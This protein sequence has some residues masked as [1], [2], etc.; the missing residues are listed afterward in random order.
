MVYDAKDKDLI[1]SG[2]IKFVYLK[3]FS[4]KTDKELWGKLENIYAGD[5]KVKEEK[6]QIFREKFEQLKMKEEEDIDAYFQCVDETKNT[7]EGLG[8]PVEMKIVVR[9]ILKTLPTRFNP[10]V[11][12]VEERS[13]MTNLSINE[14]HL[15]LTAYEM[16][17]EEEDGTSHLE[18][19]FYTSKK[20]S[21][22]M[23]TLKE[24][25]CNCK[26]DEK[27]EDEE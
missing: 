12:V 15:I 10:K 19:T 13:N 9:N 24:K 16:R 1:I 14:L 5:S 20:N 23:K 27:E 22:D 3:V 25:T 4:C 8:E 17:I 11:F 18:T 26:D 7:L 2:L 6:L 21:K